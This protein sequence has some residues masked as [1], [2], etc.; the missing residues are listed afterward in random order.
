VSSPP[1]PP[2]D[3]PEGA[4][5]RPS[6]L[7]IKQVAQILGVS[8]SVLRAWENENLVTP[9]RSASGY[10]VYSAQ[11]VDQLRH[12]RDLIQNEGLNAAGVRRLMEKDGGWAAGPQPAPSNLV[13]ERIQALRKRQGSTLRELAAATGLSA[14]TISAIERGVSAPSVG[15]LHR[16]AEALQTTVPVLLGTP[17][18]PRRL[19]V[20][21]HERQVLEMGTPGV[22]FENLYSVETTLQ[23]ILISADPGQGSQ[24]SYSHEGEEF[25]Y[26]LHGQLEIT[27]DELYTYRLG[28]QDAMTFQSPRPHR[29]FNPGK[30]RTSILWVN[31]PPTF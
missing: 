16:L 11:D 20:R 4:A 8:A 3:R 14:S 22:R 6:G 27:L 15:T 28:P 23:S 13:H 17:A 2:E 29:W 12:I 21:Q 10:R 31:T 18:N 19:V 7:Y 5:D 26:V 25:L 24:E 30:V 9:G 1:L